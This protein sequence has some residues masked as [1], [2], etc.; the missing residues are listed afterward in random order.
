MSVIRL[1]MVYY[2]HPVKNHSIKYLGSHE[3]RSLSVVLGVRIKNDES[4]KKS[5]I[6]LVL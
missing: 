1:G 6:I 3:P 5:C 2:H 4:S